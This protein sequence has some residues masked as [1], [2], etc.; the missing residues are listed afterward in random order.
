MF[1]K[2]KFDIIDMNTEMTIEKCKNK[3][4][5]ILLVCTDSNN[6][7]E[8][9]S[10]FPNVTKLIFIEK[11]LDISSKKINFY[12]NKIDIDKVHVGCN[13]RFT[14]T[15]DELKKIEKKCKILNVVS[16]SYLPEWRK[17]NFEKSY[18]FYRSKGGGA[19]LDFI[20]EPDYVFSIFGCPKKVNVVNTRN[21]DITKDSD[22]TCSMI[23]KYENLIVNFLLSYCS[24]KYVRYFD[25]VDDESKYT[26]F[27]F[28]FDEIE[29]SYRKQWEYILSQGP[30]NSYN[31]CLQLYKKVCL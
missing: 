10:K 9:A 28:T 30:C 8:T 15:Y 6:H 11:P 1:P 31:E 21:F 24:K 13:L 14:N 7:L 16:L 18:S 17:N 3:C 26:R 29:Q 25:V 20:H 19:L 22:D 2:A 4:Y 12:K 23:W 27:D 5:D